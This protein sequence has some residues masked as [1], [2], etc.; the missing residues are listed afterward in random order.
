MEVVAAAALRCSIFGMQL[1][2]RIF[3][4]TA[5][6]LCCQALSWGGGGG[7]GRR[8]LES[9]ARK[10]SCDPDTVYQSSMEAEHWPA[11]EDAMFHVYVVLRRCNGPHTLAYL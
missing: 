3:R 5:P 10:A 4:L 6:A 11:T 8:K 2:Q 9:P 7:G 1:D